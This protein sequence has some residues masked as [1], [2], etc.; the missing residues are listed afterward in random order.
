MG[1]SQS[2]LSAEEIQEH[3]A[4]TYFKASEILEAHLMFS[5]LN[6]DKDEKL[7][8]TEI[9]KIDQLRHNPF[10]ERMCRVFSSDGSGNL[11]FEE[12]LE[13][14]ST[15]SVRAPTDVKVQSLFLIYDFDQD[16]FLGKDDISEIIS[17]IAGSDDHNA[18][19]SVFLTPSEIEHVAEQVM[20]ELDIDRSNKISFY[21]FSKVM[22]KIPDL[23]LRARIAII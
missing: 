22:E 6:R 15:F 8:L 18:D 13:M 10:S 5:K 3:E 2:T 16:G 21:E 20:Q 4:N 23:S 19:S 17:R 14:L 7:S 12:F 1:G 9:Q 11:T